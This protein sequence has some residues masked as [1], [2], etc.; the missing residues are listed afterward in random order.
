M[1]SSGPQGYHPTDQ[2]F[3]IKV[4]AAI[5]ESRPLH[6]NSFACIVSPPL[7]GHA[8]LNSIIALLLLTSLTDILSYIPR[9]Q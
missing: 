6:V 3:L 9:K 1:T 2:A 8:E 7:S 4:K 5:P